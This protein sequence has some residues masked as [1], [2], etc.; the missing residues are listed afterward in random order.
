MDCGVSWA[1]KNGVS[2]GPG[3][4]V[5]T[6]M[7]RPPSSQELRR[8]VRPGVRV[9]AMSMMMHDH[10]GAVASQPFSEAPAHVACSARYHRDFSCQFLVSGHGSL[11]RC[12][13]VQAKS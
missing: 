6:V 9:G 10:V 5:L 11:Q 8:L 13:V 12:Q 7:P 2:M 4:T 3:A 1:W